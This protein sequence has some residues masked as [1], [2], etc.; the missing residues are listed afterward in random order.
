MAFKDN[1]KLFAEG[2]KNED[3]G[4]NEEMKKSKG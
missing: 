1:V 4:K 3:E 2:R